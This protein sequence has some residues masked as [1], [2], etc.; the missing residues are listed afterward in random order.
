VRSEDYLAP[1]VAKSIAQTAPDEGRAIIE[2]YE[3]Q[4]AWT[5]WRF[6]GISRLDN[7]WSG[8][9]GGYLFSDIRHLWLGVNGMGSWVITPTRRH[10]AAL[11]DEQLD[12]SRMSLGRPLR[13][14][15]CDDQCKP[16]R[17]VESRSHDDRDYPCWLGQLISNAQVSFLGS[18]L[19]FCYVAQGDADCYVRMERTSYWD[20]AAGHAI[21]TNAGGCVL[22][23]VTREPLSYKNPTEPKNPSFPAYGGG[24]HNL[25]AKKSVNSARPY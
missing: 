3:R 2:I 18:S 9:D 16:I 10:D 20:T 8:A 12:W 25:I 15:G 19:K 24:L 11:L 6:Q 5:Q 7:R 13:G 4:E 23:A 22:N 1:S 14:N 21:L 17:L